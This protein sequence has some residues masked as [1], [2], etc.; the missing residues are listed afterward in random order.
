MTPRSRK[1]GDGLLWGCRSGLDEGPFKKLYFWRYVRKEIWPKTEKF[2]T[3]CSGPLSQSI[4]RGRISREG[5]LDVRESRERRATK[6]CQNFRRKNTGKT[7][8]WPDVFHV[9]L[10]RIASCSR[11]SRSAWQNYYPTK[12]P[13]RNKIFCVWV[14]EIFFKRKSGCASLIQVIEIFIVYLAAEKL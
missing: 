1:S 5:A 9:F 3:V 2:F 13:K 7:Q 8:F 12:R 11:E 10:S 4:G 14:S 6:S